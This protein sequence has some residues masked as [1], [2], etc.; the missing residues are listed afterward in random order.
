MSGLNRCAWMQALGSIPFDLVHPKREQID[1]D[2][3]ATVLARTPRFAGHTERGVYSV[4]QHSEQGARAILRDIGRRDAAAAFLHHD[5]HEA[6]VGDMT[7]SMQD[8]LCEIAAEEARPH[9]AE[10]ARTCVRKAIRSLKT[11]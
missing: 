10:L 3:V 4:G 11:R 2:T 8:A 5:D 7:K 9:E 6:Y 1:F